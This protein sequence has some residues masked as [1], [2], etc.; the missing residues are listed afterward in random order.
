MDPQPKIEMD[1]DYEKYKLIEERNL[2]PTKET[3]ADHFIEPDLA[4]F[5]YIF[6]KLFKPNRKNFYEVF[7]CVHCNG[8]KTSNSRYYLKRKLYNTGF[9]SR[10]TEVILE[11]YEKF[12]TPFNRSKYRLKIPEEVPKDSDTLL[13]MGCLSTIK[14]PNFTLNSIKYLLSKN[15]HFT[16][17]TQEYCCGIPLVD[18]G[19]TEVLQTLM[20]KNREIFNSGYKKI[21]CVCPACFDLFNNFYSGIK[22]EVHYIA[23][24]LESLKNKRTETLSI[25]HL[26]QLM[27]RGYQDIISRIEKILTESGFKI[28]DNEKHWCCG[29]GMGLMHIEKTIEKIAR[30]RVNDFHGDILTTYCPSCYHILKLFSR[31]EKISP[32]L[33][34][35]FKLLIEE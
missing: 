21:I 29:G 9:K 13:Y 10:S 17:L 34:D 24:F 33:V 32:K 20:E 2:C 22:P 23:E 31:K 4:C 18:S 3:D 8:C 12:N 5:L 1:I 16:I 11:S 19:E 28:L 25:Q 27:N 14:V 15:I 6:Q 7:N 26:C 30:I 35:I